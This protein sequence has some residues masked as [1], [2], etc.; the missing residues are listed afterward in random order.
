MDLKDFWK[1]L[2]I[3]EDNYYDIDNDFIYEIIKNFVNI[4]EL[5]T[6]ESHKLLIE[7]ELFLFLSKDLPKFTPFFEKID[8]ETIEKFKEQLN[9]CEKIQCDEINISKDSKNDISSM[10]KIKKEDSQIKEKKKNS[11][12]NNSKTFS[13][14]GT[15][16]SS[17]NINSFDN[18]KNK[19]QKDDDNISVDLELKNDDFKINEKLEHFEFQENNIRNE[20]L[21]GNLY[22]ADIVNYI[23]KFFYSLTLGNVNMLRNK[24]YVDDDKIEYELDFQISNLYI[25]DFLNFLALLYPNLSNLYTLEILN[26]FKDIF[27]DKNLILEKI[28]ELKPNNILKNNEYI[29]IIGEVTLDYLNIKENK[30]AQLKKYID[31]IKKL[32]NNEYLNKRFNFQVKN[33][34]IILI[35]TDGKYKKFYE[36]F[37]KNKY[38]IKTEFKEE[39]NIKEEPN[40]KEKK[41]K[42]KNYKDAKEN[43]VNEE[44]EETISDKKEIEESQNRINKEIEMKKEINNYLFIYIRS[45][46]DN[47][48]ILS[49][50]IKNNYIKL[51]EEEL[52]NNNKNEKKSLL[53]KFKKLFS[54]NYD[55]F[56]KKVVVSEKL[57]SIRNILK[58]IN[59]RYIS[60]IAFKYNTYLNKNMSLEKKKLIFN[61][62]IEKIQ[63]KDNNIVYAKLEEKYNTEKE[64]FIPLV[65]ILE[66]S[67][68]KFCFDKY[69]DKKFKIIN[70]K[71]HLF[72]N[73][74]KTSNEYSEIIKGWFE[75]ISKSESAIKIIILN[76]STININLYHISSN[77]SDII[78]KD[79]NIILFYH[80]KLEIYVNL[81]NKKI[82]F[83][84]NLEKIVLSYINDNKKYQFFYK[85]I[86]SKLNYFDKILKNKIIQDET[87]NINNNT[88][89]QNLILK[90]NQDISIYN[91]FDISLY[92]Q[93]IINGESL[94]N[95]IIKY[96]IDSKPFIESISKEIIDLLK[97]KLELIKTFK[98][99][100]EKKKV[101]LKLT[102]KFE[103]KFNDCNNILL[104]I[105]Y[106]YLEKIFTNVI[107]KELKKVIIDKF[108]KSRIN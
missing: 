27:S 49:E 56:Y 86:N 78:K 97:T 81:I 99:D 41:P 65:S 100:E 103:S 13:K 91:N 80:V 93:K 108:I 46:K 15:S 98:N 34:K 75:Q 6:I 40:I 9:N 104:N 64:A 107:K 5:E 105:Y 71:K 76:T 57:D 102:K 7:K 20:K 88:Y 28:Q 53:D 73:E 2:S 69:S 30:D 21:E 16:T 82:S 18:T 66:I 47:T 29:D 61:P 10:I 77:V 68:L 33:K 96:R 17:L 24:S 63:F 42:D 48:K 83:D 92:N 106:K 11:T 43:N 22:E 8:G 1:D 26:N 95:N 45:K 36:N 14:S 62:I 54:S 58:K 60:R 31:L 39:T 19:S 35:I 37:K 38:E 50:K 89:I 51:L 85:E 23:H 90:I 52:K 4:R 25:K 87:M 74:N 32:E 84:N 67:D 3:D 94:E 72:E 70:Y 79:E 55:D 12:I 59:D 44:N 101:I